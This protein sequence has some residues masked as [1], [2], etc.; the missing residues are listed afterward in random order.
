MDHVCKVWNQ[1]RRFN[2]SSK[3]V[4]GK[5]PKP[6]LYKSYIE[7]ELQLREFDHCRKLYEKFLECNPENW[8][9]WMKFAE[10]EGTLEDTEWVRAIYKSVV[11]QS[12]LEMPEIVWKALNRNFPRQGICIKGYWNMRNMLRITLKHYSNCHQTNC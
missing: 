7:L 2:C 11:S 3:G 10:L 12:S 5:C 1:T 4:L 8:T 9:T 6:K